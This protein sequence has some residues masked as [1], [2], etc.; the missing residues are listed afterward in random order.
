MYVAADS[1]PHKIGAP[2]IER[3]A[4]PRGE[5]L[6]ELISRPIDRDEEH[7]SQ[8]Q[9]K[10]PPTTMARDGGETT[11]RHPKGE[12]AETDHVDQLVGT[13][14]TWHNLDS[15]HGRQV[16]AYSHD[17]SRRKQP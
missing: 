7:G 6:V 13:P 4:A 9:P 3:A 11:K 5:T 17:E 15:G 12:H 14:K 8:P 2:V 1:R 16:A 10:P